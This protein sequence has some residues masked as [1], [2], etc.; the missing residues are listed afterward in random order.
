MKRREFITLVGGAAA[1][2]PLVARAQQLAK[3]PTIGI[4]GSGSAAWSDLVSALMQQLRELGWIEGRTVAI[5]YRWTEGRNER[6]ASMAAE[7]VGLKVDIIVA[8]GTPAR[9]SRGWHWH[10]NRGAVATGYPHR[11]NRVRECHRSGWRRFRREPGTARRQ[12]DWVHDFR[13]QHERKMA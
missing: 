11:A 7:L 12:R 1:A 3:L 13:I 2:W 10:R 6:Y 9:R 8:L 4:L 5:E